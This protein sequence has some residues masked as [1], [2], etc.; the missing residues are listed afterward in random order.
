MNS[1]PHLAPNSSIGLIGPYLAFSSSSLIPVTY[2]WRR[3][4]GHKENTPAAL[5][6]ACIDKIDGAVLIPRPVS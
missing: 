6:P 1:R 3:R 5:P 4:G 2:P